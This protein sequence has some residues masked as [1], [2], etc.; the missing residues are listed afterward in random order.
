M[1]YFTRVL[2]S[3]GL[4]CG[5]DIR[6]YNR[7]QN[8]RTLDEVQQL[9]SRLLERHQITL[10]LDVGAN[11]GQYAKD[12]RSIGYLG[13]IVSF[14][15]M[16]EAF[17]ELSR[18]AALDSKWE[19]RRTAV[20]EANKMI[21]L[22][23]AGNSDSSSLLPMC[24]RHIAAEPTSKYIAEE[25]VTLATIDS[26]ADKLLHENDAVWL[27]M[28]VQGY[29]MNVLNGATEILPQVHIIETELSYVPLY[30]N[31]PLLCDMVSVLAGLQYDIVATKPAFTDPV[32]GHVL[33]ADGLFVRRTRH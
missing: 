33:Q 22:H 7:G 27:K 15:P 9:R 28:D 14:E 3:L 25:A 30:E 18:I 11:R 24:D 19:C 17:N 32:T 4:K 5:V 13:K 1:S 6:R 8:S 26:L 23:V 10:V 21:T 20:G 12:L 29:E 16:V 31:Q 2:H